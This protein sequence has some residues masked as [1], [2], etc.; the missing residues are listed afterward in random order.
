MADTKMT[1]DKVIDLIVTS[2]HDLAL[3][4][5]HRALSGG[6]KIGAVI[7]ASCLIDAMAGFRVGKDTEGDDY[8]SFIR[9]YMKGYNPDA[10]YKDL[11]CKL[12]HSYSEGGTYWFSNDLHAPHRFEWRDGKII[13]TPDCFVR[14]VESAFKDFTAELRDGA[15]TS[16][17]HNAVCRYETNGVLKANVFAPETSAVIGVACALTGSNLIHNT[18]KST[19]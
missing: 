9:T 16:L 7:L 13:V 5:I 12:V 2:L 1:D 19:L 3:A 4:D 10:L 8:K 17:R 11:R 15:N 18:K 6:S 14:D